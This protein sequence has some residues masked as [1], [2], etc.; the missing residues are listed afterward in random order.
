MYQADTE[1]LFPMRVT[2]QLRD[3]RGGKWRRLVDAVCA[4]P[5]DSISCLAFNLL[6]IRLTSC[7]SCHTHSYRAMRGCTSCAIHAVKRFDG[8]DADLLNQYQ[9]SF[10]EILSHLELV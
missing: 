9:A 5:D 7:L 2:P 6:I 8:T 1:L 3:L 4:S 10:D